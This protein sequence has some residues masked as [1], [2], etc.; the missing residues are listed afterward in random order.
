MQSAKMVY[1]QIRGVKLV[2]MFQFQI[3]SDLTRLMQVTLASAGS[4]MSQ[5]A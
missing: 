2:Q 3:Y 1:R 4:Y 5:S